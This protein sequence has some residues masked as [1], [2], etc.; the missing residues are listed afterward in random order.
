MQNEIFFNEKQNTFKV[1]IFVLFIE[2]KNT[3]YHK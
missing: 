2:L 1:F 3:S